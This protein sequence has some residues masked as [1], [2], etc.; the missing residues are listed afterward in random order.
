MRLR[1]YPKKSESIGENGALMKDLLL[2]IFFKD[3]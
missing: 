3:T 2:K 1:A